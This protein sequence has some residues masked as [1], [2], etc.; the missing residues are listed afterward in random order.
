MRSTRATSLRC[1]IGS[2]PCDRGAAFGEATS[3]LD[4][5][6]GL[7][8][9]RRAGVG[10]RYFPQAFSD[11]RARHHD[12]PRAGARRGARD[13]DARPARAGRTTARRRRS[14][15]DDEAQTF[16]ELEGGGKD[17]FTRMLRDGLYAAYTWRVR[18]FKE[19]KPTRRRS[20]SRPDGRPYGFVETAEGGRARRGARRRRGARASPKRRRARAGTSTS[21]RSRS[22]SRA[23]SA[24][25]RRTRRSHLHLRALVA[26]A[27]RRAATG[28]ASW[29]SGDRLTE[30]TH[31]IKIPEAFTRRYA[32]MRSANEAIGIGSVVGMALLYVVGGIGIGLFFMLRRALGAVAASAALWGVVVGAAAGAG[33][34]QRVPAAVDDLRHR[35]CRASTF[36]AQ[37]IAVADGERSSASRCSSRCRS[38]PPRR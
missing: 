20:A 10:V 37:Q 35:R 5:A 6:R 23:R 26:D 34:A 33:V 16:V 11:R 13:R 28:C 36:L 24:G 25:R 2:F 19:A 38:W 22:S 7:S 29:S 32:S 8:P 31:F 3:I 18:Q 21:R 27:E 12:G 30:V 17:A 1:R 14:R 4:P 15:G 9:S